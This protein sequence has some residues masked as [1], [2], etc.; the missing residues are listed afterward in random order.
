MLRIV[1]YL[2]II[3]HLLACENVCEDTDIGKQV[4]EIFQLYLE[5]EL[6]YIRNSSEDCQLITKDLE[7]FIYP[8]PPPSEHTICIIPIGKLIGM[9][10]GTII[11]WKNTREKGIETDISKRRMETHI[12][13]NITFIQDENKVLTKASLNRDYSYSCG[14]EECFRVDEFKF[15]RSIK[16]NWVF[17]DI[18]PRLEG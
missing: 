1:I 6:E 17:Q 8:S 18:Y 4:N 16:G 7:V 10:S 13:F 2:F 3:A 5:N 11:R 12:R 9:E 15:N 14:P